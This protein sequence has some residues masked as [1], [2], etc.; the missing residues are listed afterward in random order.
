MADNGRVSSVEYRDFSRKVHEQ[1]IHQDRI[2]KA[3]L[4]LTYRC[5]LHCVHCYTDPYNAREYFPKELT[6][7][8][9]LRLLDDM[10][11]F[12]IL[13]LNLTGGEIFKRP[14]FFEI[15]DYA[16]RKGFLLQLYTNGTVIN[17]AIIKHL[18]A[19][20]PFSIDI[21]CHSVREEAF[22]RFTQVPGSYRRFMQG[23]EL[24]RESGLPF[25]FKT[26]AMNWNK[27]EL[28]EIKRFVESFG[29]QFGYTTSLSPRLNGDCSSLSYRIAPEELNALED[30]LSTPEQATEV[31]HKEDDCALSQPISD[32]LYRCGCATNAIHINARG[33]LGTC[34]LQYERRAS[35]REY[36]LREA[37]EKVFSEVRALRYTADSPCKTCQ[38]FSF[39]EKKP[40][41]ARW[42]WGDAESPIPYN[43]DVALNRAER[44]LQTQLIHP[45][46]R[47]T[48]TQ[49]VGGG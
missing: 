8:E 32:R 19:S 6:L 3:Q 36:P 22:D 13:W 44:A 10:A 46:K 40:T 20:P 4:E 48:K 34:T 28:P 17:E 9:I 5:N 1:A 30:R 16:Y 35:L 43:C 41:D 49:E 18:K 33:E 24:L 29:Q 39:C 14:R 26:K 7:V 23:M 47:H 42:E 37:I 11:E 21:S 31:A 25:C 38:I 2:I 12:G 15:Y 45:L 27:D